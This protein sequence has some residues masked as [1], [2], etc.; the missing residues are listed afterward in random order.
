MLLT[1]G[2]KSKINL[3][4][5]VWKTKISLILVT[6]RNIF[7]GFTDTL[8]ALTICKHFELMNLKGRKA[9]YLNL[10]N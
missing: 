6:D 7:M 9:K 8:E 3:F 10:R 2:S 5:H 1:E 4:N